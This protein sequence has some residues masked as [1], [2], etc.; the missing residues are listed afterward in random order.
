[1]FCAYSLSRNVFKITTRRCVVSRIAQISRLAMLEAEDQATTILRNTGNNLPAYMFL[2]PRRLEVS[3]ETHRYPLVLD[4]QSSQHV[5][6][7]PLKIPLQITGFFLLPFNP[8]VCYTHGTTKESE[9]RNTASCAMID[10]GPAGYDARQND[11]PGDDSK[12]LLCVNI[13]QYRRHLVPKDSSIHKHCCENLTSHWWKRNTEFPRKPRW[14]PV[15]LFFKI[16]YSSKYPLK[17]MDIV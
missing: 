14:Y 17:G 13:Y 12:L 2:H 10:S 15:L 5:T 16:S 3:R 1:M 9:W 7:Q 8:V 6:G 11:N 4:N